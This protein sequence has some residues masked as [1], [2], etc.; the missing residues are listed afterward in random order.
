MNVFALLEFSGI[1]FGIS[2]LEYF[3]YLRFL[4]VML[5]N[6]RVFLDLTT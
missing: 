6:I 4:T 1:T 2:D 5:M 3:Q